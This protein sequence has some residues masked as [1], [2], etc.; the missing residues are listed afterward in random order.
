MKILH[1][2]LLQK[3]RSLSS[4]T[5]KSRHCKHDLIK[6]FTSLLENNMITVSKKEMTN[7]FKTK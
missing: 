6:S 5:Y 3:K 7:S 4:L 2:H 1:S